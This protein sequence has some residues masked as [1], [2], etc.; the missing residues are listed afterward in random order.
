MK[1]IKTFY[2]TLSLIFIVFLI[3]V[4]FDMHNKGKQRTKA[5]SDM[6]QKAIENCGT[7]NVKEV[8]LESFACKNKYQ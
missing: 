5:L 6:A 3:L 4:L 2:K 8:S 1:Y 7:G